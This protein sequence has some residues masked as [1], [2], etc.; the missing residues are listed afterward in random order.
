MSFPSVTWY[1]ITNS[2]TGLLL[3]GVC[4]CVLSYRVSFS[5]LIPW[6]GPDW[7]QKGH[8]VR[9][10]RVKKLSFLNLS[11]ILRNVYWTVRWLKK[12]SFSQ[13]TAPRNQIHNNQEKVRRNTE[14][15]T[16]RWKKIP[17]A[18]KLYLN[19]TNNHLQEKRMRAQM[20]FLTF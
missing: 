7:Q 4:V 10:N 17:N 16:Q 6:V 3:L 14:K 8:L 9:K 20:F 18:Q 19:S 5:A 1:M 2:Q 13:S 12:L 15:N 11:F